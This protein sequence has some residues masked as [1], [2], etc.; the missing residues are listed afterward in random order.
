MNKSNHEFSQLVLTKGTAKDEIV[1][2]RQAFADFKKLLDD[3]S[4]TDFKLKTSD[5]K[6]LKV[7]KAFLSARSPVFH[8]MLRNDMEEA[9]TGIVDIKDFDSRTMKEVLRFI[10]CNEVEDLD[11]IAKDLIYA[12]DKYHLL[13]LKKMCIASI[14]ASLTV[15]NVLKS[16]E[17]ADD[18]SEADMLLEHCLDII[19]W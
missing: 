1:S 6:I 16:L 19:M 2:L 5:S 10:Y 8:A 11:K 9:Q 15:E 17:I 14:V 7:H 4:L 13:E 12:A 18:V 3:E